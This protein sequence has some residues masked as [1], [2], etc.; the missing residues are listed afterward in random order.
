MKKIKLGFT[1]AEVMIAVLVIGVIVALSVNTI[2]IVKASFTATTY[3]EFKTIKQMAAEMSA[4]PTLSGP[5][6]SLNL[7]KD[8]DENFC[9][10]LT[11][12][13]NLSGQ[14]NCQNTFEAN[15]ENI[16]ISNLRNPTFITTNGRRYYLSRRVENDDISNYGYRI[17]AVDLNGTSRPNI[18]D[19]SSTADQIT[20]R[21][22]FDIIRFMILDNGEVFPLGVAA[23]NINS[24][25]GSQIIYLNSR[26]KGY[27]FGS[28]DN[29][30]T[31]SIP[32]NC[33]FKGGE[34]TRELCNFR[35]VFIPKDKD[36]ATAGS[37]S[38]K[39]AYCASLGANKN[40][41]VKTYCENANRQALCPPSNLETKFDMCNIENIK[42]MFRYNFN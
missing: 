12:M 17:L 20:N 14:A 6:T 8:T 24:G 30:H 41:T 22:T 15:G 38:Y 18:L 21:T 39:E 36:T 3:F 42:P 37:Y 10:A 16:T 26:L 40:P 13:L 4:G 19:T 9:K 7:M 1:L 34:I 35:V 28:D 23:N 11:N 25:S 32:A 5:Q 33:T 2:K 31:G 29:G 27:Y